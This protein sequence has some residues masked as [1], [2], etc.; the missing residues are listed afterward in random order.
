MKTNIQVVHSSL[1]ALFWL[2][3]AQPAHAYLDPGTGTMIISAIVG[4]LATASL[5]IKTFWYKIKAFVRRRKGVDP[6]ADEQ[7]ASDT[8]ETVDR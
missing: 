7:L 4:L 2:T 1:L 5:A 3:L 6:E 8:E